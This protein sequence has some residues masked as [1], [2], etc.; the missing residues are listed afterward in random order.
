MNSLN[1]AGNVCPARHTVPTDLIVHDSL[2]RDHWDDRVL[3]EGLLCTKANYL[4]DVFCALQPSVNDNAALRI[5]HADSIA[6]IL[7]QNGS[8][9][10]KQ[11]SV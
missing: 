4:I 8:C 1:A 9:T 6:K 3:S 5:I 2:A 11:E 10:F 7:S